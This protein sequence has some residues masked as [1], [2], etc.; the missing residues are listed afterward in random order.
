MN[1]VLCGFILFLLMITPAVAADKP[2]IYLFD[3]GWD[4][5]IRQ[6]NDTG[7]TGKTLLISMPNAAPGFDIPMLMYSKGGY[8]LEYYTEA[9]WVDTP[10]RMLLPLLVYRLEAT[11]L[12]KAVLSAATS[13][14]AAELRL[15]TEIVRLQHL[16][17]TYPY[18]TRLVL[19]VQLLDMDAHQ[20]IATQ[21]FKIEK[22]APSDSAEG[23][24]FAAQDAVALVL[25]K[26]ENF[27]A[28][29]LDKYYKLSKKE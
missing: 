19:R 28:E 9:R 7:K 26:L 25:K 18:P 29:Q 14:I 20:V 4:Q 3:G 10:A 27:V 15:D 23:G 21:V 8:E 2:K 17:K 22:N 6:T 1:F 24:M 5:I 16:R 12:F 13:P 11:G